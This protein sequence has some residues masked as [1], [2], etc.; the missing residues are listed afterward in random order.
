MSNTI[1]SI[2]IRYW[3]AYGGF[4]ALF[5]SIYLW[6]ALVLTLF[7]WS[8]WSKEDWW[9][10]PL[11]VLPNLLGFSLG[12]LAILLGLIQP[13]IMAILSQKS[14]EAKASTMS[15]FTATFTHFVLVQASALITAVVF[16]SLNFADEGQKMLMTQSQSCML[17]AI[18]G[19]GWLLFI[20][21]VLLVF[22]VAIEVFRLSEMLQIL[23]VITDDTSPNLADKSKG[24]S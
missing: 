1:K 21:A 13:K 3:D 2:W 19:L 4:Q 18:S 7:G 16:K 14:D 11:S 20:Y 9:E 22:A 6:I 5:R 10:I 23:S 12:G 15:Q 17:E 24:N 8:F